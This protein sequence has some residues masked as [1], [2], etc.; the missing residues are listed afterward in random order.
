MKMNLL[1]LVSFLVLSSVAFTADK[2][3]ASMK[4]GALVDSKGM[5]LYTFDNDAD[6]KSACE[7]S[8]LQKWPAFKATGA[9]V[10]KFTVISRGDGSKQWA[11]AG[12]PL[13]YFAKDAKPGDKNGDG[14]G[15][16]WHVAGADAPAKH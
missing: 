16:V 1:A 3:P 6:G 9:A 12:K 2:Q 8:C 11:L 7:G 15:G 14:M 4:D 5:T 13:Y 10:D